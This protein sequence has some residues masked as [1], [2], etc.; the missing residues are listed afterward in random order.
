MWSSQFCSDVQL[1]E[2]YLSAGNPGASVASDLADK[3]VLGRARL[4]RLRVV[5]QTQIILLRVNHHGAANNGAKLLVLEQL[6][7]VVRHAS[8]G[9]A[10]RIGG[11]VAQPAH[12]TDLVL[13][14]TVV[15]VQGVPMGPGGLAPVGEVGLLVHMEAVLGA[16]LAKILDVPGNGDCIRVGLLEGHNPCAR[17]F[18]LSSIAGLAVGP[19]YAGCFQREGC[20]G[21]SVLLGSF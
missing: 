18:R 21:F 17:L 10:L 5:P 20:H 11:D 8:L 4:V 6:H 9:V 12:V 15:Q 19:H 2:F 3:A 7:L 1:D 13:R 14:S 16:R